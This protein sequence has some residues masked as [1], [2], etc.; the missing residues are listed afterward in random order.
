MQFLNLPSIFLKCVFVYLT[1]FGHQFFSDSKETS[2]RHDA[3][4]LAV[5]EMGYRE[6]DILSVADSMKESG[7]YTIFFLNFLHKLS[8]LES[9]FIKKISSSIITI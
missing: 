6:A 9:E 7:E 4:V 8:L 3:A 5:A 2:L 1:G